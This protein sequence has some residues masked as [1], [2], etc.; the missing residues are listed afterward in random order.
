MSLA[1]RVTGVR[2]SGVRKI[3]DM[4]RV[5][6][7]PINMSLGEPD[8]DVPV[9]IKEE[10]VEWT[11]KGFN[12]YPPSGGIPELREKLISH[13]KAKGVFCEDVVIT[14]GVTGGILL[15]LMATL[16]PGDEVL[17]PDPSFVMYEY[18]TILLGGVP[19][20]IDT[21]PDFTLKEEQ[22][23]QAITKKTRIIIINSPN[24]PTGGVCSIQELEMV[25]RIARETDIL[26]F[27]D[28]IYERFFYEGE[29]PPPCLGQ[30]CEGVLTFGGFSK[31]WGMTGWRVGYVAGP[32]D[33]IDAMVTMLQYVFS[34]VHSVAQKAAV[35]ALDYPTD[36]IIAAYRRKRDLIYEGIR[37][38]FR[39]VKPKGAYYIFPEAPG[40][41][42]DAFVER[43]IA[44]NLF[45]IPGNVFSRR[46]SH[47][48]IS[49]AAEEETVLR[50]I[51]IL[52][53]LS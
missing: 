30:L 1:Q 43:A 15:A 47:V 10:A 42:G 33:T 22:I 21:Y 27:S 23:R 35:F 36:D 4:V 34:G 41:D 46:K 53:K 37:D 11:R 44:N 49:F 20:F 5:A 16:N 32:K 26:I 50:G 13:L 3:F 48:R 12:K 24:N 52:R 6:K 2:P 40:G 14:P 9:P 38:R 7:D 17:I 29:S 8:F 18:Q 51:E 31:T 45:I 28:D 19:V 25:A 39:V